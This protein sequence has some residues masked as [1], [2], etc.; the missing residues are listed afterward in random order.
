MRGVQGKTF[1][2]FYFVTH[3]LDNQSRLTSRRLPKAQR[4]SST[5]TPRVQPTIGLRSA[6]LHRPE[7]RMIRP[8]LPQNAHEPPPPS[9]PS[10]N[11]SYVCTIQ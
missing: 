1:R 2:R 4:Q 10:R 9:D 5:I 8:D 3:K 11:R 6:E 7:Q